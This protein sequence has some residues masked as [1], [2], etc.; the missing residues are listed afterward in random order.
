M[1]GPF[2]KDEVGD[3]HY[4]PKDLCAFW[5]VMFLGGIGGAI[6]GFVTVVGTALGAGEL[7]SAMF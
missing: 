3:G 1:K 2:R 4:S 5:G 6:A 7:I